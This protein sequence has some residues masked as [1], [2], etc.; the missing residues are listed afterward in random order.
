L[1]LEVTQFRT[2]LTHQPLFLFRAPF[3]KTSAQVA[4]RQINNINI[5]L[6]FL[7]LLKTLKNRRLQHQPKSSKRSEVCCA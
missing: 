1:E 5:M 4:H 7:C 6:T 3:S 2:H